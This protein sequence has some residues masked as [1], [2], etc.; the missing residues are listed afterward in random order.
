VERKP[1][2]LS[3]PATTALSIAANVFQKDKLIP[4]HLFKRTLSR[5]AFLFI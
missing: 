5:C 3:V 4:A 1:R 2:Y